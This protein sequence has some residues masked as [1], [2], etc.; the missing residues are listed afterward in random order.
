M[1]IKH[2]QRSPNWA[3]DSNRT[4]NMNCKR[5]FRFRRLNTWWM[6]IVKCANLNEAH[7]PP[8]TKNER[9]TQINGKFKKKLKQ[10]NKNKRIIIIQIKSQAQFLLETDVE[11]YS[12]ECTEWSHYYDKHILFI[13]TLAIKFKSRNIE[14]RCCSHLSLSR[15]LLC[16][17]CLNLSI[18][19]QPGFWYKL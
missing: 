17:F 3:E 15:Y 5:I 8:G 13:L 10:I 4:V 14:F 11:L 18:E 2:V 7:Q 16:Y 19:R 9:N 12:V 6:F 1:K